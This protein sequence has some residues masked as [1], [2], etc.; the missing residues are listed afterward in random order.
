MIELNQTQKLATAFETNF[1]AQGIQSLITGLS[2]S[3]DIGKTVVDTFMK[4]RMNIT[5]NNINVSLHM[6]FD[7]LGSLQAKT[8][9]ACL[10]AAT[11]EKNNSKS[12]KTNISGFYSVPY[13]IEKLYNTVNAARGQNAAMKA[14]AG[15][16]LAP[17]LG[18]FSWNT[19]KFKGFDFSCEIEQ[20]LHNFNSS[21][22]SNQQDKMTKDLKTVIA[23]QLN[24]TISDM[25]IDIKNQRSVSNIDNN[26]SMGH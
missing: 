15:K 18:K 5:N 13:S 23:Y 26:I 4:P 12:V 1:K 24:R 17:P 9:V 10:L 20:N 22:I 21:N 2:K 19:A 11:C 16:Q 6:D 3:G 7:K 8:L 14:C 25:Q